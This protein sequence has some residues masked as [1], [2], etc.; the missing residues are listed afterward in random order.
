MGSHLSTIHQMCNMFWCL[1]FLGANIH[2]SWEAFLQ[3]LYCVFKRVPVLNTVTCRDHLMI[4]CVTETFWHKTSPSWFFKMKS[5]STL[6]ILSQPHNLSKLKRIFLASS[7]QFFNML[8]SFW[9]RKLFHWSRMHSVITRFSAV[10]EKM[11][12]NWS[13]MSSSGGK[14]TVCKICV[15]VFINGALQ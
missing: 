1:W 9:L 8:C 6:A 13:Q 5:G 10:P 4:H 14:L 3:G 11:P 12:W 2:I 7:E 15:S